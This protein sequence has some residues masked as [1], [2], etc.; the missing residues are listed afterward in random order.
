[1]D[2]IAWWRLH[3]ALPGRGLEALAA[4]AC[5]ML[6]GPSVGLLAGLLLGTR[7]LLPAGLASG[8]GAG[9]GTALL[10]GLR[11]GPSPSR[12][13]L[14]VRGRGDQVRRAL[15]LGLAAGPI[16]GTTFGLLFWLVGRV[17][18][19]LEIGTTAGVVAGTVGGLGVGLMAALRA[20]I[21]TSRAVDPL[22][23]LS[24]DRAAALLQAATGGLAAA[25]AA[26][27]LAVPAAGP[28]AAAGLPVVAGLGVG[29]GVALV[30]TC[31]TA[32]GQW[33]LT[34]LWL[35]GRGRTPRRL[36]EFLD[37]AHRRGV[38]RQ[39]GAVHQFRHSL[40][41]T[42]LVAGRPQSPNV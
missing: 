37:D 24:A 22:S 30:A 7:F 6:V 17:P 28:Q 8:L 33:T 27:A 10:V 14:A 21:E 38:L 31:T 35:A 23:L 29:I 5:A 42:H 11:R 2:E 19:G 15:A 1:V 20:P 36:M 25:F 13:R 9:L 3:T 18:R 34:R 41:Q 40:L 12:I 39:A 4:L 32:W 16:A 26:G